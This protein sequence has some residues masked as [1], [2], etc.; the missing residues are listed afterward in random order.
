MVL[1]IILTKHNDPT[2]VLWTNLILL[3]SSS[4]ASSSVKAICVLLHVQYLVLNK[5]YILIWMEKCD[6]VLGVEQFTSFVVIKFQCN[7]NML[8]SFITSCDFIF[9]FQGFV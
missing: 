8:I 7:S 4:G 3:G 5:G 6:A 9:S 2:L 1:S